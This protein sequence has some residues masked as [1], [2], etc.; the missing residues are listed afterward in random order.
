MLDLS[1][2][3]TFQQHKLKAIHSPTALFA[4]RLPQQQDVPGPE[5]EERNPAAMKDAAAMLTTNRAADQTNGDQQ[6][7]AATVDTSLSPGAM[8]SERQSY[9]QQQ[10]E[11]DRPSVFRTSNLKLEEDDRGEGQVDDPEG[12]S[13]LAPTTLPRARS[14]AFAVGSQEGLNSDDEN[15]GNSVVSP[16]HAR[17]RRLRHSHSS[18]DHTG[19]GRRNV[20]LDRRTV[21]CEAMCA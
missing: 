7:A 18:S 2:P 12:S 17:Q 4:G 15:D 5:R 8:N 9:Q 16:G 1:L 21:R 6:T 19:R 20:T 11:Q 13:A 14:V 10:Q 3:T